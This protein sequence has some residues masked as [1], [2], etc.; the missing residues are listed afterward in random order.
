[1]KIKLYRDIKGVGEAEE[2]VDVDAIVGDRLVCQG[3]AQVI[4]HD[5]PP[6]DAPVSVVME[7]PKPPPKPK[8]SPILGPTGD[9]I[10]VADAQEQEE[11]TDEEPDDHE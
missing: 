4:A 2:V 8:P 10:D 11:E 3:Q 5:P 1:M 6:P 9:P 7:P